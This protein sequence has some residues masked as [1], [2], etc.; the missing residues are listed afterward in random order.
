MSVPVLLSTRKGKVK[1]EGAAVST[2][3]RAVQWPCCFTLHMAH[4]CYSRPSII[5]SESAEPSNY[6]FKLFGKQISSVLHM[7]RHLPFSLYWTAVQQWQFV[8]HLYRVS[9]HSPFR[10]H[11]KD[12]RSYA[13]VVS[14]PRPI[15]CLSI[16][17]LVFL[18]GWGCFLPNGQQRTFFLTFQL[19]TSLKG[20]HVSLSFPFKNH[21][22]SLQA[23]YDHIYPESGSEIGNPSERNQTG[24]EE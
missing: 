24:K 12:M 13:Q 5:E 20:R 8:Q 16:L 3:E 9:H 22:E 10:N 6:G 2:L 11:F 17:G 4:I 18:R 15:L 14:Q 19:E 23:G 21:K 7:H 1:W